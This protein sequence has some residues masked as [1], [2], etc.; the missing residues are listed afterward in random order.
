MTSETLQRIIGVLNDDL[1]TGVRIKE[2]SKSLGYQV[3]I[4]K[5]TGAFMALLNDVEEPVALG[6]IDLSFPVEWETVTTACNASTAPFI[7][8]GPHKETERLRAAKK[9]G[10]CRVMAN[11]EFHRNVAGMIERY[12]RQVNSGASQ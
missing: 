11:S 3:R 2:I 6:I 4:V 9:A 7:A 8:F 1:F 10:A 5:E 12:A